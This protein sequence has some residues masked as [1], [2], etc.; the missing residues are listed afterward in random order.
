MTTNSS[1]INNIN[2]QNLKPE[3]IKEDISP[4]ICK[5]NL[6]ELFKKN[7]PKNTDIMISMPPEEDIKSKDPKIEQMMEKLRKRKL[8]LK[9]K[10]KIEID[11]TKPKDEIKESDSN[12]E[13]FEENIVSS[14]EELDSSSESDEEQ[15]ISIP[16]VKP[17][18]T[19]VPWIKEKYTS[20]NL[21]IRLHEE[22]ID[23]YNFVKPTEKEQ[24]E[25]Q[26][27][28]ERVINFI[29]YLDP[30]A[31]IYTFGSYATDLQLPGS[32]IDFCVDIN[33][34]NDIKFLGKIS[35]E[36][37][38]Q[39][40]S[41]KNDVDFISTAKV[42]IVR[43][44]D[45]L[46]GQHADISCTI[47]GLKAV[48]IIRKYSERY[49]AFKYLSVVL[50]YFLKQRDLNEVLNGGISSYSLSLMI[51]NHLQMHESNY[52]RSKV[53][54]TSLGTLLLD[55]LALFGIYFNYLDVTIEINNGGLYRK[56]NYRE[57]EIYD[58]PCIIDPT[59][60][61]NNVSGGSRYFSNVMRAFR[62][63][64]Y[65]LVSDN[66]YSLSLLSKIIQID[67][68]LVNR[69]KLIFGDKSFVGPPLDDIKRKREKREKKERRESNPRYKKQ[70]DRSNNGSYKRKY[71]NGDY[72]NNVYQ[73][74]DRE[75]YSDKS[76]EEKPKKKSKK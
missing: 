61:S 73:Y 57:D 30:N 21:N 18:W 9:E 15:F 65:Q 13:E 36:L 63:G 2:D 11:L 6:L 17:D 71:E 67:K 70:R 22:I 69:R 50:K 72:K 5:N 27:T 20:S 25:R 62:Y 47:N 38:R 56:K 24:E 33:G 42:P 51:I 76:Y 43:F 54:V 19:N 3:E 53:S 12:S 44:V 8:E 29:K 75:N 60:S 58:R 26:K 49:P 64:F 52:E 41:D 55:F 4:G 23:F 37:V 59:N 7:T 14:S 74:L 40:I 45:K 28:V 16:T 66:S 1:K 35:N 39:G 31:E 34:K 46:T 10:K 68:D 48:E 32:D